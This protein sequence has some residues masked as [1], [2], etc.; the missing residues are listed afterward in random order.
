MKR[1]FYLVLLLAA[2]TTSTLAQGRITFAS[3]GSGLSC[4]YALPADHPLGGQYLTAQLSQ[5]R[6]DLF[7]TPGTST[8]GMSATDLTNQCH[9]FQA[10]SSV[11]ASAGYFFAGTRYVTNWVSGPIVAQVRVWDTSYGTYSQARQAPLAAWHESPLIVV[12]PTLIPT[13]APYLVGLGN[14]ADYTL[15]LNPE[16]PYPFVRTQPQS[17]RA[18]AGSTTGFDAEVWGIS[19]FYYEWYL[20][21]SPISHTTSGTLQITNVGLADVGNYW[22]VVTNLYG[23]A[24]SHVA[25]LEVVTTLDVS[26]VPAISIN[27]TIGASY[28]LEYVETFG[29]VSNWTELATVTLTNTPQVYVDYSAV[30]HPRRFYRVMVM[31]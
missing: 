25:S 19:P 18:V 5:F 29:S 8:V 1:F 20:N 30:G 17:R 10:F 2:S 22:F 21:E 15:V 12:T 27:G 7:W 9:Y 28:R 11:A 13:P 4:R 24:T 14:P 16:V 31:P 26:A 23:S 6:A 3:Y